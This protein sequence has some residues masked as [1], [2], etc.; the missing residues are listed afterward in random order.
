MPPKKDFYK[1]YR[2]R[3]F[4]LMYFGD[5]PFHMFSEVMETINREKPTAV[6][7]NGGLVGDKTSMIDKGRTRMKLMNEAGIQYT[8]ISS[9]DKLFGK[10]V[11]GKRLGEF[12]GRV[13]GGNTESEIPGSFVTLT[14]SAEPVQETKDLLKKQKGKI[15]IPI[16]NSYTKPQDEA[17][18]DAAVPITEGA[19]MPIILSASDPSASASLSKH[20]NGIKQADIGQGSPAY[21]N[22]DIWHK[23]VFHIVPSIRKIATEVKADC[24][25]MNAILAEHAEMLQHIDTQQIF[26]G[27]ALRGLGVLTGVCDI[28][29][30]E[31]GADAAILHRNSLRS[32]SRNVSTLGSFREVFPYPARMCVITLA[33][34]ALLEMLRWSPRTPLA[35]LSF[36]SRTSLDTIDSSKVYKTAVPCVLLTGLYQVLPL[37]RYAEQATTASSI[38]AYTSVA[39][40]VYE[41]TV[42]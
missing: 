7:M 33:G 13:L 16:T 15:V 31:L 28:L 23:H 25:V 21:F 32:H 6:V 3:D 11:I 40:S 9:Q 22:I 5:T 18:A 35:A 19:M 1:Y 38:P 27:E 24:S 42:F 14:G 10:E 41:K 29:R 2:Y 26:N 12:K 17:L 34:N 37:M 39:A 8:V 4:R 36:D 30:D 20:Y